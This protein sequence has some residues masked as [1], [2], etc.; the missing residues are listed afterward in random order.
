[1]REHRESAAW[2]A[3]RSEILRDIEKFRDALEKISDS[4]QNSMKRGEIRYARRILALV[5]GD[6]KLPVAD[7]GPIYS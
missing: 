1:M 7:D 3:L 5:E 6:P 2:K 4:E